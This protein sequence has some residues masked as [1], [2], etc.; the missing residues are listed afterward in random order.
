MRRHVAVTICFSVLAAGGAT[1][2][3]TDEAVDAWAGEIT[4]K[5]TGLVAQTQK[6]GAPKTPAP[7]TRPVQESAEGIAV[8]EDASQDASS[9]A[10]DFSSPTGS[11]GRCIPH[12]TLVC[13]CKPSC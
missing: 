7:A 4:K 11:S 8:S 10:L 6:A 9:Q 12:Q 2:T 13:A 5:W 3:G 1:H